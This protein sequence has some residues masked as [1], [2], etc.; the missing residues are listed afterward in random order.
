MT[1]E[2]R[3]IA[4]GR[5][6]DEARKLK[7]EIA[8]L[9]A[10]FEDWREKLEGA[11]YTL[12]QFLAEPAGKLP[13]GSTIDRLNQLQRELSAPGLFDK[14]ADFMEKTRKLRK[15]EDQIKDF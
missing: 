13:L 2:E 14:A 12:D 8:T 11:K 4:Q 10:W 3:Y 7:A 1:D 15:L 6:R 5:A 9:K